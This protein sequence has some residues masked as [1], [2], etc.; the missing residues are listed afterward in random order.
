MAKQPTP[1]WDQGEE[2]DVP[3]GAYISWGD[4]PGQ[5]VA[6]KV[7]TYDVVGGTDAN[8]QVCPQVS[9]ELVEPAYSV[10]RK[11][12]RTDYPA[13]EPVVLNCGQVSLKRGIKKAVPEPGAFVKIELVNLVPVNK[14]EV[15]EFKIILIPGPQRAAKSTKQGATYDELEGRAL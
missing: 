8:D 10:N 11:G 4:E 15:K 1:D 6:G 3:R 2:I 12:I 13:G 5:Y 7:L 9:L 14:G